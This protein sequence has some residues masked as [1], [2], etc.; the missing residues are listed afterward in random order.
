MQEVPP[1]CTLIAKPT[2]DALSNVFSVKVKHLCATHKSVESRGAARDL[3]QAVDGIVAQFEESKVAGIAK[4][5]IMFF[6]T[7]LNFNPYSKDEK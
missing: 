1:S 7:P 6:G 5:T 3:N 4:K 2:S